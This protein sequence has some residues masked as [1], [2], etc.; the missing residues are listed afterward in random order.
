[1]VRFNGCPHVHTLICLTRLTVH[2]LPQL[3]SKPSANAL[4]QALSSLER[5]PTSFAHESAVPHAE[6]SSSTGLS[7]LARYLTD[8]VASSLSWIDEEDE[9]EQVWHAASARLSERSGRTGMPTML[10]TFEI[11]DELSIDLLE[12]SLTGDDLGLKTWTSSLLL[13]KRLPLLR[14]YL[15]SEHQSGYVRV[16]ELGAGTG[17]VGIAAACLWSAAVTLTDLPEIV[18][19]LHGNVERNEV[20]IHAHGGTTVV[21]ALDWSESRCPP[22][23]LDGTYPIVIAAD[24]IYSPEHP[25]ML[26]DTVNTWLDKTPDARFVLELPLR[27]G[28]EA[29]RR[30]VKVMLLRVGLQLEIEGEELGYDDWEGTDGLPTV[31]TCWWAVYKWA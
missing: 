18:P 31:V 15:P 26:V 17:L 23:R 22:L 20:L 10:R 6:T 7:G 12:P 21:A 24:P 14:I 8:V 4:L 3:Y 5:A 29:E 16:L 2:D 30:E 19:N 28:Y 25:R 11:S 13:A 1:M 9:R 27:D